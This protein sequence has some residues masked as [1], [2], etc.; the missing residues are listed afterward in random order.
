MANKLNSQ[1]TNKTKTY[2][3]ENPGPGLGQTQKCGGVKRPIRSQLS[4][5]DT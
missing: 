2:D 3:S 4:P 1:N 5:L